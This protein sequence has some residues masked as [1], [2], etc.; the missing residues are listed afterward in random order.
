MSEGIHLVATS[1]SLQLISLE[2]SKASPE[3]T[4]LSAYG[5]STYSG[6]GRDFHEAYCALKEAIW[7]ATKR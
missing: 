6:S 2:R 5:G 1:F 7:K 3:Y 4:L